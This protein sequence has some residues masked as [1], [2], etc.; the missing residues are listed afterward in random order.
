MGKETFLQELLIFRPIEKAFRNIYQIYHT[1]DG[2]GK[3]IEFLLQQ[4]YQNYPFVQTFQSQFESDQKYQLSQDFFLKE[5]SVSISCHPR[6]MLDNFHIHDFFEMI[7]VLSGTCQQIYRGTSYSLHTGD[8]AIMAPYT[9]HNI[10]VTNDE[11]IVINILFRKEV[12][13]QLLADL[14]QEQNIISEFLRCALYNERVEHQ[15]IIQTGQDESLIG[16]LETMYQE[17]QNQK[18]L[19]NSLM[20]SYLNMFFI[21]LIRSH[22]NDIK[23]VDTHANVDSDIIPILAEIQENFKTIPL[24]DLSFKYHYTEAY[25]SK[26]IKTFTKHSFSEHINELRLQYAC[27]LLQETDW[28]VDKVAKESG[29]F[30]LSHFSR[31]FKTSYGVAPGKYRKQAKENVQS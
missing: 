16:I 19:K 31:H 15:I 22:L 20:I 30:D 23:A 2:T 27:K 1:L 24:K 7:Y 14:V 21:Q 3:E 9:S 12:L 8:I 26:K 5:K 10:R 18:P 6:Y 13:D 29:F 25:L 28:P 17:N 4:L 11:T